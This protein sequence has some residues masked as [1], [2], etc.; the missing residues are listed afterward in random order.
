MRLSN[1][2][3]NESKLLL[4]ISISGRLRN[5]FTKYVGKGID[6]MDLP[7][8]RE[9]ID[10]EGGDAIKF[11][12]EWAKA[13]ELWG[14]EKYE[15]AKHIF[16]KLADINVLTGLREKSF[17]EHK[18]KGK[19]IHIVID[20]DNLKFVNSKLGHQGANEVIKKFAEILKR[21][22]ETQSFNSKVYRPHGA[23]DEFNVL[24]NI[25]GDPS[26]VVKKK[27]EWAVKQL[28]TVTDEFASKLF[29][30]GENKVRATATGAISFSENLADRLV[31][32]EKLRRSRTTLRDKPAVHVIVAQDIAGFNPKHGGTVAM[33]HLR[34]P[35]LTQRIARR[36]NPSQ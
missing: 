15:E 5:L 25:D 6:P 8:V 33:L 20:M 31:E 10:A 34:E 28:K 35:G 1:I 23:G 30:S 32:Q 36:L 2:N 29:V 7:E 18:Q 13:E 12:E 24:I 17:E 11:G 26:N 3:L 16:K 27:I 14:E 21:K 22:F 19:H 9:V 4:E